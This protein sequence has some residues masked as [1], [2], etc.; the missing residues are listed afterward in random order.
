[1]SKK[2]QLVK[3]IF[4]SKIINNKKISAGSWYAFCCTSGSNKTGWPQTIFGPKV[5]FIYENRG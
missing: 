5:V 2:T 4:G 1:M 3:A